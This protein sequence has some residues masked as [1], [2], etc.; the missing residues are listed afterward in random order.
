VRD[1]VFVQE[2]ETN[3]SMQRWSTANQRYLSA[4]VER[5]EALLEGH[6]ARVQA[7]A[8]E[9]T[10]AHP[11]AATMV[12]EAIAQEMP[13]PPALQRL[14]TLFDLGAFERDLL[15]LCAGMELQGT[16][17]SRC[18]EAQENTQRAFPTF[19]LALAALPDAH[20]DAISPG[21]PLRYWRLLE[22]GAG[23]SLTTSPLRIDER[24][25][26]YLTGVY[27][28]DE[29]LAGFVQ[30]VST[31]GQGRLAPSQAALAEKIAGLWSGTAGQA[32]PAIQLCGNEASARQAIAA[33]AAHRHQLNL[34]VLPA[35]M[36]PTTPHELDILIRL[37]EREAILSNGVLLLD[38]ENIDGGDRARENLIT[39]FVETSRGLLLI[40]TPERRQARHRPLLA[41]DVARPTAQE[42][43]QIWTEALGPAA[44]HLNG[45][46]RRLVSHFDLDLP[47]I[48]AACRH[49]A[50]DLDSHGAGDLLESVLWEACRIQARPRLDDLAQRIEPVAT[51]SEIVL[52]A[53]QLQTLRTIA[54][55]VRQRAQVYDEWGFAAKSG[56]GLGISALFAGASG[57]G[58]TMAAEVLANELRLDL[59]RIDLSQV[60][61]KYIGE[62]EKNLRRVFDAAETGGAILLFDEADALFGKRSEVKDSHDRYANIEV[63]YLLQRMESYRGLAILTSNLKNALDDAFLR[64]IRFTVHF[65]FPD[66]PQRAEIWQRIF[67]AQTPT[68]GVDVAK[69][70]RL[71]VAGGNIRNIALHGAFLA[72]DRDEPVRMAHLLQAARDE[73]VKLEKPLTGAEIRGWV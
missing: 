37:W 21:A 45:H 15:L 11:A 27:H 61:S 31:A 52:P 29:Q 7:G 63:S 73:Y 59:Y 53:P 16:F 48:R 42:Q 66:A 22:V 18:A 69:L 23:H 64:R 62:T 49:A 19:S 44:I 67:P 35:H 17:A 28:L 51:W 1:E 40:A 50:G 54:V 14:C 71:N 41:F 36:L 13:A 47:T 43:Q 72:A 20:W 12:L 24:I 57:T 39:H 30:P 58:K 33:A 56:R 9:P 46:V 60:V 5:I 38:C 3:S 65:P 70:A 8:V 2:I 34:H 32:I 26:H 25:L 6:S 10:A 68:D 55:H 4:A